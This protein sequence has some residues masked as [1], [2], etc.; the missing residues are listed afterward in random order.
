M[1][2]AHGSIHKK[3]REEQVGGIGGKEDREGD[4]VLV[5]TPLPVII[6][7]LQ[8]YLQNLGHATCSC[9][10]LYAFLRHKSCKLR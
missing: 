7:I 5:P 3:K 1:D 2:S 6:P 10:V 8:T 9:D 4:T